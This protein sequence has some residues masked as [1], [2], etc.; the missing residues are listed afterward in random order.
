VDDIDRKLLQL[1][2]G[3][4]RLSWAELGSQLKI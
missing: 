4:A 1:L 2:V 3:D